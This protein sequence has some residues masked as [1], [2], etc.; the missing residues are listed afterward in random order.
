[1][2]AQREEVEALDAAFAK[3][4]ANQPFL[5][6]RRSLKVPHVELVRAVLDHG[7]S[8]DLIVAGQAD[9]NWELSALMDFPEHPALESG[10]LVLAVPDA[11][12]FGEIGRNVVITW[13]AGRESARAVFDALPILQNADKV[14]ILEIK[15][16]G[17]AV[18]HLSPHDCAHALFTL[19]ENAGGLARCSCLRQ[20]STLR[21]R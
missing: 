7:R 2:S 17:D 3:A 19:I 20:L 15:Q 14:H 6:E 13:K 4:T 10:R 12:R 8:A 5:A 1:M 11:G 18:A 9:P 16:K 21:P